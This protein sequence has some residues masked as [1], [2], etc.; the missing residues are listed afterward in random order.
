MRRSTERSDFVRRVFAVA[1]A[2]PLLLMLASPQGLAAGK[3][4]STTLTGAEEAPGP[5]DPDASGVAKLRL[6]SG[7]R[8]ICFNVSW[9]D[10][11]GTVTA[12]HIHEAPA[13]EPGDV[14]VLLFEGDHAGTDSESGC[15]TASR[16]LI[17]DIRSNPSDYYVNVHS[18]DFP[19]GAVRGQLG[20]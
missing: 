16:A 7:K 19:G 6:N 4:L 10:V 2:V 9:T 11:D 5:G 15:V 1:A 3:K 8:T 18:T 20:D 14:V 17:K 13:G 12:S